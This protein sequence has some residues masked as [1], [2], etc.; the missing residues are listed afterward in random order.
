[1]R[2]GVDFDNTIVCYDA[3]FHRLA[4]AERLIPASLP[5]AKGPI[6]DY[7]RR[8]GREDAWTELQ[9]RAYGLHI[10]QATPFPGVCEFFWRC[11]ARGDRLYVISHKTRFPFLGEQHDL[12]AAGRRW[13][14]AHG[15][16]DA[17]ERGLGPAPAEVHFEL[18]KEAKLERIGACACEV[19]ID[20]LP[21]FLTEPR[22]PA[23]VRR[24]LF[25]PNGTA[26]EGPDLERATSW[27]AV[28][29]L[30]T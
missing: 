17:A 4:L 9:G 7:L 5:A 19:F 14:A 1:M 15:F 13:L 25:D 16:S 23:G 11:S 18:T 22:F 29:A 26:P 10:L 20:D 8:A 30:L 3:L 21:E 24:I 28:E 12:H 2:I 6:R 27:S